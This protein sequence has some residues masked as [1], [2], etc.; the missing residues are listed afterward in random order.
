MA[1]SKI[2]LWHVKQTEKALKARQDFGKEVRELRRVYNMS[3]QELAKNMDVSAETVFRIES[4]LVDP[5]TY[6]LRQKIQKAIT[7][8]YMVI[9]V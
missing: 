2:S 9:S 6:G 1:T 3:R 8:S 4:G 7:R 5:N